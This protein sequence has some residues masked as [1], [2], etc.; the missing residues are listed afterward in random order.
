MPIQNVLIVASQCGMAC[1]LPFEALL[2]VTIA[3]VVLL[4]NEQMLLDARVNSHTDVFNGSSGTSEW[5][6]ESSGQLEAEELQQLEEASLAHIEFKYLVSS[7]WWNS[8]C[9]WSRFGESEAE[10]VVPACRPGACDNSDLLIGDQLRP[11]LE[12]KDFIAVSQATWRRIQAW[13]PQSGPEITCPV[14]VEGEQKRPR[15][16]LY[17]LTLKVHCQGK[18]SYKIC[19]CQTAT[20]AELQQKICEDLELDNAEEMEIVDFYTLD[21]RDVL[22]DLQMVLKDSNLL[23]NQDILIKNKGE[24]WD[25]KAATKARGE[26]GSSLCQ[27][28]PTS[29]SIAVHNSNNIVAPAPLKPATAMNRFSGNKGKLLQ[30]PEDAVTRASGRQPGLVGLSNLGNTCYMNSSLQCLLHTAPLMQC[31]LSGRY[32]EDINRTNPLGQKGELAEAFA[33]LMGSIWKAGVQSVSPKG[34]KYKIGRFCHAFNGYAQHDSQELLAFLLDGLHEDMNRVKEKPYI[35]DLDDADKFP[36]DELARLQWEAHLARNNSTIV[37]HCLGLYRSTLVC[38]QCNH[39]SRKFDPVMYLSLP[40]PE[41]RVRSCT[42][43]LI[44]VDGSTSP[45]KYTVEVPSIGSVK[46]MLHALARVSGLDVAPLSV[47]NSRVASSGGA[48]DTLASVVG[49]SLPSATASNGCKTAI[50]GLPCP[51][52]VLVLAKVSQQWQVSLEVFSD[53]KMRVSEVVPSERGSAHEF[54]VCYCYP[55]PE[56]GPANQELQQVIV[57]HRKRRAGSMHGHRCFSAPLLLYLPTQVAQPVADLLPTGKYSIEYVVRESADILRP[58][59]QA[60]K[61]FSMQAVDE[62]PVE[63]VEVGLGQDTEVLPESMKDASP[64]TPLVGEEGE[65]AS[66]SSQS[67]QGKTEC[68][69]EIGCEKAEASGSENIREQPEILQDSE[70]QTG[71]LDV[72]PMLECETSAHVERGP[73]PEAFDMRAQASSS[74]VPDAAPCT[75]S[76]ALPEF[77]LRVGVKGRSESIFSESDSM[78]EVSKSGCFIVDWNESSASGRYNLS[79]LENPALH[80]SFIRAEEQVKAGRQPVSLSACVE[81][82]LQP[83]QLSEADSWYCPKCKEHVQADKKLDLWHLP[84]VLVVHL[85]RFSYTRSSR[86]KLNTQVEFPLKGLDLSRYLLRTQGVPPIYDC[87]AVSNHYGGMGGGHYTAYCKLPSEDKWYSFDD[88][89]VS[90]VEESQVTGS[91]AYVLFY[92]RRHESCQDP[93]HKLQE[94]MEANA[95]QEL[96][97]EVCVPLSD[98]QF[99]HVPPQEDL[100]DVDTCELPSGEPLEELRVIGRSVRH[101]TSPTDVGCEGDGEQRSMML[102][103]MQGDGDGWGGSQGPRPTSSLAG[104]ASDFEEDGEPGQERDNFI[105]KAEGDLGL[106]LSNRRVGFDGEAGSMHMSRDLSCLQD[107]VSMLGQDLGENPAMIYESRVE[108]E[109]TEAVVDI[110]L[111]ATSP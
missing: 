111:M 71:L 74:A 39:M 96:D 84:E 80:D 81:A 46:D 70:P 99:G 102:T 76:N 22:T 82:F 66:D 43:T 53:I 47:A 90:E 92:R 20:V 31:F 5:G 60:L 69:M 49:A 87:Y 89:H 104:M 95:L 98:Q 64:R 75:A 24:Q 32:K 14:L 13:Y 59:I 9:K 105:D 72:D 55:A 73:S 54:L 51:Q 37:D 29:S 36:D 23:N 10:N 6:S 79:L 109:E 27:P 16:M 62:V 56:H 28:K 86:E 94:L 63:G 21:F 8:W 19:I 103:S 33:A 42:I 30:S 91:A 25:P 58:I 44:H 38:P 41:S 40:L 68:C 2:V 57:H 108:D 110:D 4:A 15:V 83:E 34:F 85:K 61:P 18:A 100:Q 26:H 93:P 35:Q 101:V 65:E 11:R 77:T 78:E 97:A 88:S 107:E 7:T 50:Q 1:L 67:L 106:W 48:L 12:D 3:H 52:D 45:T 17:P